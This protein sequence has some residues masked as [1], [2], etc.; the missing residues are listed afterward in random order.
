MSASMAS[1]WVE[2]I[3]RSLDEALESLARSV[4]DCPEELWQVPMWRVQGA[5]IA[6]VVCDTGGAPVTDLV[7]RE[8]LVQ[9]RSTWSVAWHALEV[10]DYDLAGELVAWSPPPPF[11]GKPHWRTFT[12]LAVPWSPSQIGR[13]TYYCR[14]RVRDTLGDLP[15]RRRRL[16]YRRPTATMAG[17]TPRS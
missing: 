8:A 16:H 4:R 12:S 15:R 14:Q 1:V 6:G 13:Y 7:P 17:L 10:L 3:G 11:A 5:D 9:R 2:S